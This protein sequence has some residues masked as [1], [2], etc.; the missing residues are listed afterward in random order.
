MSLSLLLA[1]TLAAPQL[2]AYSPTPAHPFGRPHPDAPPELAQFAFMIGEF[3]CV[4]EIR[5]ADGSWV[6]TDAIWNASYFLNGQGIQD[7][8]W[9]DTFATS[10]IRIFDPARGA[11]FVNFVRTPA[12]AVT[13]GQWRGEQVMTEEGP[14]MVMWSGTPDRANGSRLTFH[15]IR[16]DGFEWVAETLTD[17]A[18]TPTWRS[19]CKRRVRGVDAKRPRF[20]GY[21]ASGARPF[22]RRHPGAPPRL[23]E[24]EFLLGPYVGRDDDERE[25]AASVASYCLNGWAV[26]QDVFE[27]DRATARLFLFD[28]EEKH[29]VLSEFQMPDYRWTVWVGD[30]EDGLMLLEGL[31]TAGATVLDD[32]SMLFTPD[33]GVN[34]L[35]GWVLAKP[36]FEPERA[37]LFVRRR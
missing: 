34:G 13:H 28:T 22:G 19:S 15:D 7:R 21:D 16:P 9:S 25:V 3:D 6:R 24:L 12:N 23:A 1:V 8:Y 26:Q 14:T 20:M 36:D 27:K 4:D 30:V 29:F 18:A 32:R 37:Q 5:Q 2:D 33:G 17:G 31:E 10:N 35:F 11:W